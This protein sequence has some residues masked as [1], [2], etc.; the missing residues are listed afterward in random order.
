MRGR[1]FVDRQEAG[2]L[3]AVRLTS[4]AGTESLS[5]RTDVVVLGLARG[6]IPVAAQVATELGAPLDVAVVRKL[7]APG[8]EELAIGAISRDRMLVNDALMHTLRVTRADLDAIVERER[9]EL[10]RRESLY[11]MGRPAAVLTDATVVLVDDGVA[12]GASMQVAVL[13]VMQERPAGVIVAVP[14]ASAAAL[15]ALRCEVDRV[16]CVETPRPFV[17]VG[18]SY[19]DF[20]QVSDGEVRAALAQA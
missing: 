20:R 7:G 16:V 4:L 19:R 3:L 6:G 5:D 18:M 8:R 15:T 9:A 1:A 13:A 12:T 10:T 11:R 14:T 17:A 2:R